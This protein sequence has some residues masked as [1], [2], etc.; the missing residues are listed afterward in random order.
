MGGVLAYLGMKGSECVVRAAPSRSVVTAAG[1]S[2]TDTAGPVA[3]CWRSH[4]GWRPVFYGETES[5][6]HT[7]SGRWEA[8][9]FRVLSVALWCHQKSQLSFSLSLEPTLPLIP[10]LCA[11]L[12]AIWVPY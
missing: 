7:A 12:L 4:C 10:Q 5:L 2:A 3:P 8:A 11:L 9:P 6:E 1:V